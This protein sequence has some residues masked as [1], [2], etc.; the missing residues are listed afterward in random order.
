MPK[1]SVRLYNTMTQKLEPLAPIEPDHVR[2]YV[3]GMTTYDHAHAG[4]ARTF[5]AFDVLVRHLRAR[6]YRV[7]YVRNMTDIDDKI[8]KRALENGEPPLTLS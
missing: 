3:C 4:H 8:L 2:I 7:T 6:G 1:G 5:I